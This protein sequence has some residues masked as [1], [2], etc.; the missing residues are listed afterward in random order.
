MASNESC[1][2]SN[3]IVCHIA[4]IAGQIYKYTA[5]REDMFIDV[6]CHIDFC[7][8]EGVLSAFIERARK[9][10]VRTIITNGVNPESNRNALALARGTKEIQV[11]LGLYPID[12]LTLTDAQIEQE[13]DFIREKRNEIVAIGE[14]GM[15]FK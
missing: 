9:A 1:T 8:K 11:A 14:V 10:Q 2:A 12:A 13:L 6:H 7:E 3:K 15:D 4:V 5:P